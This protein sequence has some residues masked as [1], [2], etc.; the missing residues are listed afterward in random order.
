MS[1]A[2]YSDED[3][4]LVGHGDQPDV[5]ATPQPTVDDA[6]EPAAAL[7]RIS[8]SRQVARSA[9]LV[10]AVI[11]IAVLVEA[12]LVSGLQHRSAQARAFARFRG[13]LARGEA[14][15]SQLDQSK[16][17]LKLGTPIALLD[18][19]SI[20]IH[21]VVGEGTTSGTLASG[22]G[23]TR[24]TPLPGE[25]GTSVILGRRAAFG[26]PF[27]RL[28]KIRPGAVITVTTGQGKS[29]YKVIGIRRAGEAIPA[30]PATGQGRLVLAT[31]DGAPFAPSGVVYVD[32]DLV[33]DAFPSA[34]RLR[35]TIGESEKP[36]GTD[37]SSGWALVLWLE[38]LVALSLG[39]VWSWL[40]WGKPQTWIVFVPVL[41]FAAI[42][43]ADQ[44]LRL[45]PNLT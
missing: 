42:A 4:Q 35:S 8:P 37:N 10:L 33:T 13:A 39:A 24:S 32:A 7:P 1:V 23:H 43:A 22:P 6:V 11:A 40:R 36:L 34:A 9:L 14:P 30:P 3:D 44:F 16:H 41:L 31:A 20:H 45:L 19:P 25:A 28:H 5:G 21:E 15:V 27:K 12:V 26:G 38:V 2:T 29:R 17:L 18:I